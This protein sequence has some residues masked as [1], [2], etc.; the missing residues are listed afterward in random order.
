M[1]FEKG[2]KRQLLACFGNMTRSKVLKVVTFKEKEL[3]KTKIVIDWGEE[4]QL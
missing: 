3:K 1:K 2:V 4:N